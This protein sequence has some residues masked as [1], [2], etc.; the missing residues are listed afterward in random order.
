MAP[1]RPNSPAKP[2][3]DERPS[4]RG[5][6]TVDFA[7]GVGLFLITVAF[8]MATV[9]GMLEPFAH[10]QDDPLVADRTASQLA[11]G[12]LGNPRTPG[13]LNETCTYSFFEETDVSACAFDGSEPVT[14]QL[15]LGNRHSVNV[16]IRR[17]V[18]GI[19]DPEL[20]CLLANTVVPCSIGGSPMV[21][22]PI[23]P[24]SAGSVVS[25]RRTVY[26]DGIDVFMEVKVW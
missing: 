6:T 15:N 21:R 20:M 5:Q 7:I 14:E 2:G 23:P 1:H 22:G 8:V 11:E 18:A 9:P 24:D 19:G 26:L 13:T 17:T 16:T 10:D 4:D 3:N 12:H 25:S